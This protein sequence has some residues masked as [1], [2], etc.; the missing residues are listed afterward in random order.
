MLKTVKQLNFS[1]KKVLVRC[2]FNVPIENGRVSDTFKIE[3][4]IPTI[5]ELLEK[6]SKIILISHLGRPKKL[7]KNELNKYS[8]LPV[9]KALSE[10]LKMNVEFFPQC[11]GK[12]VEKK[13]DQM[14][15]GEILL[16]ENLR[17]EKGEEEND[18]SF[19][20]ELAKLGEVYVG[21]AFGVCHRNHASVVTL[22][23]LLPSFAGLNLKKEIEVLSKISTHPSRPLAVI[24]GGVKIESKIKVIEKFM[25]LADHILFGGKI[26]NVILRVKGICV[27]KPWPE[28][29]IVKKIMKFNLTDSKI[30]LPV[31]V[32]VSPDPT[33]EV[34]VRETGPGNVL[35]EEDIFDIGKETIRSF[36]EILKESKTIFWS[37]PLGLA[38]NP[39][40][41]NGT[42]Q[43]GQII[44][45]LP[46][47]FSVVGGGDTTAIL[48]KFHLLDKFSF[49]STGGG[50][51]LAF[52]A[53]ERLPG[54]EVLKES[55]T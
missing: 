52:L 42:E 20:K 34:Y 21:E 48:R 18:I 8:L 24:I 29:E 19:A 40:F 44:T 45:R 25:E 32:L 50:A 49:A 39:N 4:T 46:D 13:V 10:L 16:L 9:A 7:R 11:V 14:K 3:R 23:K 6:K 38:E 22:A 30:H 28:E 36:R 37:G 33:G 41:K 1:S 27:G 15:E 43:I 54:V 12:K 5:L 55:K 51:M 31:D 35:K 53:G 47:V 2:D 26:A 17:F